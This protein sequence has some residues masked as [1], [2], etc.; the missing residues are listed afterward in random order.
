[1]PDEEP[2][3]EVHF[4]PGEVPHV[5]PADL[6]HAGEV[7]PEVT[8]PIEESVSYTISITPPNGELIA[9]SG[10]QGNSPDEYDGAQFFLG[11]EG[12]GTFT[13]MLPH[14]GGPGTQI[15]IEGSGTRSADKERVA[16]ENQA[17][18]LSGVF[19]FPRGGQRGEI[20]LSHGS[21]HLKARAV[22]GIGID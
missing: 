20:T 16:F 1:M 18:G 21:V 6:L 19:S 7:S 15:S 12:R 14:G 5:G 22:Q 9:F 8:V 2:H 4:H 3:L 11:P 17:R 13:F 10:E